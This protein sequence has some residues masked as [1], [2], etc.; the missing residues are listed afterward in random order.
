M[1]QSGVQLRVDGKFD[2]V[3]LDPF[4]DDAEDMDAVQKKITNSNINRKPIKYG[5]NNRLFN[6]AFKFS[7]IQLIK[8]LGWLIQ[9]FF[10]KKNELTAYLQRVFATD[11]PREEHRQSGSVVVVVE[12]R[13]SVLR[14]WRG[15]SASR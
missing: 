3:V 9:F 5:N 11:P 4:F 8:Y 15:E 7:R 12:A 13:C 10:L 6:L 14:V 1:F 2:R